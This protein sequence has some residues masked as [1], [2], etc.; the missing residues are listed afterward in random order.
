MISSCVGV[1]GY[2]C[3]AALSFAALL[4]RDDPAGTE[5]GSQLMQESSRF[6]DV[7]EYPPPDDRVE[8]AR[9]IDVPEVP[10]PEVDVAPSHRPDSLPREVE[11]VRVRVDPDDSSLGTDEIGAQHRDVSGTASQV[12]HLHPAGDAGGQQ[13][14][15]GDRAVH[16]VLQDQAAGLRVGTSERIR[17]RR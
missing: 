4:E 12:E 16:L 1:G 5:V 3:T 10:L 13:E 14:L 6:L 11:D 17:V 9:Q 15:P 8:V 2:V 7:H